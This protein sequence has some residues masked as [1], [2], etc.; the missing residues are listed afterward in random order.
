MELE[1]RKSHVI[2]TLF[3]IC[4]ILLFMLSALT[5]IAI[6]AGVYKKN[7]QQTSENYAQ[8]ISFA[9]ITEKVRQADQHGLVFVRELF[10]QE[11]LV[12][13]EEINGSLYDTY[14]YDHDGYLMELFARDDLDNFYPQS[15]QKIYKLNSFE[16]QQLSKHLL[17]V[18]VTS[19]DGDEESIHI[20]IRS[21]AE[22]R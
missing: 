7:V 1:S 21:E 12:L 15:G 17:R 10:G 19:E 5:V 11:V 8:R 18:T 22:N 20:A 3:V 2:D 6:G 14:I 4:L 13:Q 9:Y 16:I